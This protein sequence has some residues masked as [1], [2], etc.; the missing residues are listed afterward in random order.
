MKTEIQYLVYV[1]ALTGLL[2]IPY[3]LDR[4]KVW[5]IADTVGYPANPKPLDSW[6]E[7]LR[8]A[9]ANAVENLVVFAALILA[10]Q[11]LQVSNSVTAA[12]AMLYFWGRVVHVIAY[13]FAMPW[14]RTLGFTAGFVAQALVAWQILAR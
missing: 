4:F 11:A 5:G 12:A 7:R 6:A 3:V 8:K 1:A 2:W 13:T 9:H 14:V 10:A